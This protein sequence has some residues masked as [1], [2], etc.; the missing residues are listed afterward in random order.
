MKLL[1]SDWDGTLLNS[2]PIYYGAVVQIF[3]HFRVEPPPFD[4]YRDNI[5]PDFMQFYRDRGI[6]KSTTGRDLNLIRSA[7]FEKNWDGAALHPGTKELFLR[8]REMGFEVFLSTAE[9]YEIGDRRLREFG[10]R[11]L[12]RGWARGQNSRYHDIADI[13]AFGLG[14]CEEDSLEVWYVD[15]TASGLT[16]AKDN[17]PELKTIGV[18]MGFNSPEKIRAAKPDYVVD[19]LFDIPRILS[20]G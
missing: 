14:F 13:I 20:A 3:Q 4:D 12:I 18:T 5:T 17:D 15:D 11:D 10:S 19:S 6:P 16:A 9:V 2:L 8:A 7:Y 1:I